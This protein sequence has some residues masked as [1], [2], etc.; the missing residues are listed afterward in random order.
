MAVEKVIA[1]SL[2]AYIKQGAAS[3]LRIGI[4]ATGPTEENVKEESLLV[5]APLEGW[6][7]M[8]LAKANAE[9][10]TQAALNTWAAEGTSAVFLMIEKAKAVSVYSV[11]L[12]VET[13]LGHTYR[14]FPNSDRFSPNTLTKIAEAEHDWTELR[15]LGAGEWES[16][17][18]PKKPTLGTG[19]TGNTKGQSA[20]FDIDALVLAAEVTTYKDAATI[21]LGLGLAG[22][23]HLCRWDSATVALAVAPTAGE[24]LSRADNGSVKLAFGL[25]AQ[26]RR[27]SVDAGV[28]SLPLGLA[29]VSSHTFLDAG[30]VTI[31]LGLVRAE[32]L[33]RQDVSSCAL[34]MRASSAETLSRF[35]SGAVSIPVALT[36]LEEW[37]SG[38]STVPGLPVR[39]TL[40]SA[41]DVGIALSSAHEIAIALKSFDDIS[42]ESE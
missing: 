25:S 2:H 7:V 35:S 4:A 32:E 36:A 39:V 28:C 26:E 1:A 24:L 23:E 17:E 5:A 9:K 8:N 38:D 20:G 29:S 34:A 16:G 42:L 37:T 14:L 21:S 6:A 40:I 18:A 3:T 30:G 22:S 12:Q 13:N 41:P 31:P 33:T 19:V 11:Y 27:P 10:I 15:K